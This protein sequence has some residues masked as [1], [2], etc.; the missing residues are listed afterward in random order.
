MENY[1]TDAPVDDDDD[2][3]CVVQ[4]RVHRPTAIVGCVFELQKSARESERESGR[5]N[6]GRSER[7][8]GDKRKKWR[9]R[10]GDS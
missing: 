8:S 10:K 1:L 7:R 4:G 3:I 5:E 2:I 6:G 9:V